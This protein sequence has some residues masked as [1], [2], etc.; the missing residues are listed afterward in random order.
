M[1]KEEVRLD[2]VRGGRQKYRRMLDSPYT[3]SSHMLGHQRPVLT[4]DGRFLSFVHL[5]IFLSHDPTY[6]KIVICI[7]VGM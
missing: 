1:L 7:K 5:F 2:C 6:R 4:L 3:S